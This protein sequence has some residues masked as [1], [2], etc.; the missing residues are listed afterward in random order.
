MCSDDV[1]VV[2]NAEQRVVEDAAEDDAAAAGTGSV[3]AAV[4]DE[5]G[6]SVERSRTGRTRREVG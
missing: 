6:D 3:L 5:L 2:A 4:E 1:V